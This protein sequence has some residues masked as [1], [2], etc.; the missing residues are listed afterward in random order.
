MIKIF[1]EKDYTHI[2]F[3][4][5]GY[6]VLNLHFSK[7]FGYIRI[8]GIGFKYST[9]PGLLFSDRRKNRIFI[10]GYCFIRLKKIKTYEPDTTV[11]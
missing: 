8:F 7:N 2:I 5:L 1:R 11:L 10:F 6:L 3:R 4:V 9:M